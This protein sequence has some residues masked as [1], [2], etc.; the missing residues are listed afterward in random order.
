MHKSTHTPL[1]VSVVRSSSDGATQERE[2]RLI[3]A[4]RRSRKRIAGTS[5]IARPSAAS[6]RGSSM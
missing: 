5:T 4:S 3:S 6:R 1:A 2:K